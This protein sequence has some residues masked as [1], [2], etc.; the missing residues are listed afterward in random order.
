MAG[1]GWFKPLR[2]NV[3][4]REAIANAIG[5][6]FA[7]KDFKIVVPLIQNILGHYEAENRLFMLKC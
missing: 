1:N 6:L 7:E 3:M 4:G 5:Q 2:K